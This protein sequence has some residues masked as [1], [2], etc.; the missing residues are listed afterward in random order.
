[1]LIAPCLEAGRPIGARCGA[2]PSSP[3]DPDAPPDLA[4][5]RARSP[6]LAAKSAPRPQ[7]TAEGSRI[8]LHRFGLSRG[9]GWGIFSIRA[10]GS[11]LTEITTGSPGTTSILRF[12]SSCGSS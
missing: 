5:K 3:A 7:W 9:T 8:F 12:R 11:G 2:V 10:D 6:D 4:A 1:M